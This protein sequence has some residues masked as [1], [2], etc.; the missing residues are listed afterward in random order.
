VTTAQHTV[1]PEVVPEVVRSPWPDPTVPDVSLAAFLLAGARERADHL[2]VVDAATGRSLTYA[3][4]ADQVERVAAGLAANNMRKGDVFAIL[5]PNSPEWL[6]ACHGAITAGGVVS[7]LNPLWS[8]DELAS[9]LR[10]SRA[11]FLATTT[12]LAATAVAAVER[13]GVG[14]RL[15]MLDAPGSA[16]D[17]IALADLAACADP[18]PDVRIDPA[19]DLALLPYSSGTT[20]LPKGVMLTHSACVA[21]VIQTLAAL[22][23]APNDRTLAVAP[24]FHAVGW[25]VV[26]NCA[27]RSGATIVTLP[28]FDVA[29]F[30]GSVQE[31]RITQTVVVPPV[32]LALARHPAV[33]DHDLSTLE[34][35]A[36]GAAPL[37]ASLQQECAQRLG[38]PVVQGF[39]MTESVATIAAS[40]VTAPVVPGSCGRLLPGVQ[41]RIDPETGELWIRSPAL[42]SGYLGQ[43]DAT[44]HTVDGD[45]WLH[46]GDVA[47]FDEDGVLFVVD[48]IK[49]LIKVK[50][51]QVAPAELEAV[52]RTHPAVVD[53]A[54]IA[55]PDERAGE[56]P[57]ACVVARA[58]VSA[59]ELL[60]HVAARVAPYKLVRDV[61]FVDTIPISP[62][63][64]IL[65]RLLRDR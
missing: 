45:G 16:A 34:W 59:Q 47:R 9:Q 49:E 39:G 8:A 48:R 38:V 25:G 56:V 5:A 36:C 12:P 50:A 65:R 10:D 18:A 28:R 13:A 23:I 15:V 21:N 31:H 53:A 29:A 44:A 33:A 41:A 19:V 43:P 4:L 7:G 6:V 22:P 61:V 63:G 58:P 40:P 54:V 57:R 11:R 30:L 64:K 42:M 60:D 3:A 27:L 37:A 46:T 24:F 55:I 52:L 51:F 1:V 2:A 32:I 26:A 35:I 14:T 62:S 17:T 20:G